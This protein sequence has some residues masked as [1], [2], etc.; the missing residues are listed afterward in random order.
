MLGPPSCSANVTYVRIDDFT[1]TIVTWQQPPNTP[2]ITSTTVTFCPNSSPNC[3]NSVT[4]TSPCTISGL[5]PC[6]DYTITITP[7]NNCGS[8][9]GCFWSMVTA[10]G[11]TLSV[12]YCRIPC[13]YTNVTVYVGVAWSVTVMYLSVNLLLV[14]MFI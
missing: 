6:A 7:T 5:D 3:G 1:R 10:K 8:A 2:P 11:Y 14:L 9:T 13:L 4:C 12:L